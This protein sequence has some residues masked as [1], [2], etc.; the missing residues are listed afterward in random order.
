MTVKKIRALAVAAG[1]FF[2]TSCQHQA[3]PTGP[4]R[5]GTPQSA[6]QQLPAQAQRAAW[7]RRVSPDVMAL[8]GTVFAD[9]DERTGLLVFGVEHD[10]VI[11]GVRAVLARLG[12]PPSSYRIVI[13]EPVHFMDD[14]RDEYRPTLGGIQIAF[15]SFVCTLGFNV[16]SAGVASFITNSHC[17][18]RIGTADGTD[19]FQPVKVVPPQFAQIIADE[20]A[21][22]AYFTGGDCSRGKRCR[23]SDA[24][25]AA[26]RAG[27]SS[28]RGEI[29]RTSGANNG[30]LTVVGDFTITEQGSYSGT[31][32]T[33]HKVG[34]ST[35]WTSGSLGGT[36]LTI[37][38]FGSNVQL[39]CQ[40]AVEGSGGTT[41]ADAG[42]SG[43]PVFQ[44]LSGTNVRLV[45]ILWGGLNDG[46]NFYFSPFS[47]IESELGTMTATHP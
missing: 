11:P 38:P 37:N 39:L 21:D 20:V 24:A 1:V 14:L 12:V 10:D 44:V 8:P 13:T 22:P 35:G 19:Y 41:M 23:Y 42:D 45:G 18:S 33:L 25:R 28:D 30:S 7:F 29:A 4:E 5:P 47:A 3:E 17:S 6:V 15:K 2:T 31:T 46:S 40:Y 26:Y 16:S 32:P 34:R 36:C 27:I 43:S 9:D